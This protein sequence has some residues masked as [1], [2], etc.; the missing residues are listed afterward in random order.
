[1]IG[2]TKQQNSSKSWGD[3]I[4]TGMND[5]AHTV[6]I[7]LGNKKK[8][9]D[10]LNDRTNS[11]KRISKLIDVIERITAK[12]LEE[13]SYITNKPLSPKADDEKNPTCGVQRTKANSQ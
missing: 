11:I 5:A 4:S 6:G 9:L 12:T 3:S 13:E 1:M 8:F 10:A 7:I 2:K